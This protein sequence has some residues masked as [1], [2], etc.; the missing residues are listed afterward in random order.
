MLCPGRFRARCS[1]YEDDISFKLKR[2]LRIQQLHMAKMASKA[3][4]MHWNVFSNNVVISL[5]ILDP[6]QFKYLQVGYM[7]V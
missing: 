6:M 2:L 1:I 7:L 5:L 3:E 4:K